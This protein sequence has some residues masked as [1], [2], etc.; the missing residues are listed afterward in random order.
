M[1]IPRPW[2]LPSEPVTRALLRAAGVS[3]EMLTTGLRRGELRKLRHGVYLAASAWPGDPAGQ[4]LV[5]ARAEVV[6]N[7]GGVL[8]RQSAALVWRLPAPGPA[9]WAELPP[10]VSLPVS[11]GR[12]PRVGAA[13]HHVERLPPEQVVRDPAGYAVTSVAR[14]AVDLA[15]DLSLPEALVLLDAATRTLCSTFVAHPRRSDFANQRLV[16]AAR[17]QLTAVVRTQRSVRLAP[18]VALADPAR[19]SAA[20]SLSAGQFHL[21]GIPRPV[22]NPPIHTVAGTLFPDCLWPEERVIGEC[23]GA[24]KYADTAAI[25]REKEREQVLR[26]AGFRIVRW[27]AR[28][29]MGRPEVVVE[30]VARALGA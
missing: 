25:L 12:R 29:V 22:Y 30:R 1:R 21:A 10:S 14:T 23:D 7:P 18:A 28:E 17:E 4:H 15:R 24:V 8:S 9:D 16:W 11:S 19:E 2:A 27:Q 13:L 20:E 5:L 6:A 26:D 3:D